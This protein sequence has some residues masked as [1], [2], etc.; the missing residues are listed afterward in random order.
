[1]AKY[2][3]DTS[4]IQGAA[5]VG[6]SMMPA[7]LS[8]LD[9]ITKAGTDMLDKVSKDIKEAAAKKKK[10]AN[11]WYS[12]AGPTYEAAGSFMKKD[13][14]EL[15][16]TMALLDELQPRWAAAMDSGSAAEK[17]A[18]NQEY[19]EI[20]ASV[21]GHK[22]LRA[23][24]SDDLIGASDANFNSGQVSGDDGRFGDFLIGLLKEDYKITY[25]DVDGVKQKMYTVGDTSYTLKQINDKTVRK[26]RK[27]AVDYYTLRD[28]LAKKKTY[29]N[30]ETTMMVKNLIPEGYN[31][32]RDFMR[33]KHF[34]SGD[35]ASLLE[36]DKEN[37]K[38]QIGAVYDGMVVNGEIIGKK[39]G[40]IDNVEFAN[41]VSAVTDPYHEMW[42]REET[43]DGVIVKKVDKQGWEDS[44]RAISTELL[45][46]G[47]KNKQ[48]K[49]NPTDYKAT[50]AYYDAEKA[51]M[52]FELKQ[53]EYNTNTP[54]VDYFKGVTASNPLKIRGV[55]I[56]DKGA[57]TVIRNSL[58]AGGGFPIGD[59]IKVAPDG[60][61]GWTMTKYDEEEFKKGNIVELTN[62]SYSSTEDFV[63][64][65]LNSNSPGFQK[66]TEYG[67]EEEIVLTEEEKKA[68]VIMG[69]D[70]KAHYKAS[71]GLYYIYKRK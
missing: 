50:K 8:G 19:Q 69:G 37:L 48:K 49:D 65:G 46:N 28:K 39:D 57:L 2:T 52:D 9:K 53:K 34:A 17:M 60:K 62:Q 42:S 11:D 71:D 18:V 12:V 43:V 3:S 70:G 14:P 5:A 38:K 51:R 23:D 41:Y 15:A 68:G 66:L 35:F 21:D 45:T 30:E 22:Q 33:G 54:A 27:P 31:E 61:G 56:N 10:Q 26:N 13:G 16:D 44:A 4:L 67:E 64:N 29:D 55:Q 32:M 58:M 24:I 59:F 20:K 7:D 6:Q 1:M 36:K 63:K 40:I 25:K 47:I